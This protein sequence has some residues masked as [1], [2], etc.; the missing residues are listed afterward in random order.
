MPLHKYY[1]TPNNLIYN[2]LTPTEWQGSEGAAL[3]AQGWTYCGF[4]TG[5]V[6]VAPPG[7][8]CST[9]GNAPGPNIIPTV[10][11]DIAAPTEIAGPTSSV[12]D[13]ACNRCNTPARAVGPSSP[14]TGAP[15]AP[16]PGARP[17]SSFALPW[18]V[19]VLVALT[20]AQVVYGRNDRRP[21]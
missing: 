9:R 14:I 19:W 12:A 7:G 13:K 1:D 4:G 2:A 5:G 6:Y 16:T 11:A 10:P 8:P 15:I 17:A 3:R 20:L 18:W 21:D